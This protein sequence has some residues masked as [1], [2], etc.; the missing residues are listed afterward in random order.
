MAALAVLADKAAQ[1]ENCH[2]GDQ[3]KPEVEARLA[4][5]YPCNQARGFEMGQMRGVLTLTKV[6][7]E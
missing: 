4:E 2:G 1:G 5:L 7:S 3:V 6:L